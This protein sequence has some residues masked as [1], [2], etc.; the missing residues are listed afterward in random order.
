MH[1]LWVS[2]SPDTP[3]GFGTVTRFVCGGL[4]RRG[5]T[6][7]VLG[8]QSTEAS[9][10][11]GCAVYPIGRFGFGS[12]AL[13]LYLLER[14]PDAVVV[15]GDIKWLPSI[16]PPWVR[17][18]LVM[19]ATPLV[20][21]FPV[22]GARADGLL[23]PSWID[24]L[25]YADVAVAMSQYGQA[26]AERCG[27]PARHIPHGVDLERF[28]PP[29]DRDEAKRRAG[30]ADRFVV[31]SD[32]RNQPRKMLPRLLDIFAAFAAEHP[33]ALL[34]L[35]TD[36][37]DTRQ[38]TYSYDVLADI[39]HH[40]LSGQ[41]RV[42]DGFRM[43]RGR[44]LP[45]SRLAALY[46]A[47]DVHL[48]ASTGEGFGL[49][50]LQAAAVGA[51]PLAGAH[52]ACQELV[53]GHGHAIPVADWV[54]D[55]FGIRRGLVDVEDAAKALA[56]YCD[57]ADR[58]RQ[59]AT[60]S[61]LFAQG[62]GWD[63]TVE[64]WDALLRSLP[65][66]PARPQRLGLR[67]AA[68]LTLAPRSPLG[69]SMT[70]TVRAFDH[71]EARLAADRSGREDRVPVS[72]RPAK[73][74]GVTRPRRPG[75][76]CASP[77]DTLQLRTLRGI[78]PALRAWF[79]EP[80]A[81]AAAGYPWYPWL[82]TLAESILVLNLDAALPEPVLAAAAALGVPCLGTGD[83]PLQAA[84]WP[85]LAVARPEDAVAR[86]RALLTNAS[87]MDRMTAEAKQIG[88]QVVA[89]GMWR[90]FTT[91]R[92]YPADAMSPAAKGAEHV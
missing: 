79:P 37:S 53:E 80:E 50:N 43:R 56:G 40:G 52:S 25:S 11:D 47:A 45:L 14:R 71:V 31:L 78:F 76:V 26:V 33:R 86:A 61:R 35:H 30:V 88:R 75:L 85:E 62:Y 1:L 60:R 27:V 59:D 84:L 58:L 49:P 82:A 73:V 15:L 42:T 5:H 51:V 8:W 7:S 57:D 22:D 65:D 24:L 63:A 19:T 55:E 34:H 66:R 18:H 6:V 54:E 46:Q 2:D 9:R 91:C 48:L 12:D 16:M 39:R 28:R 3:S 20:L 23:P 69:A 90:A 83:A 29:P 13:Y 10:H 89:P 81:T 4:A 44:G 87:L 92:D 72:P 41:A 21:Y 36:P 64:A 38:A 70:V 17:R 77:L 67:R 68:D 32:S 74:A